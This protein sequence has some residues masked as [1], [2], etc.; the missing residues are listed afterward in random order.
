ME[1][2]NKQLTALGI[3]PEELS[4]QAASLDLSLDEIAKKCASLG[5]PAI[6]LVYAFT[7]FG[8]GGFMVTLATALAAPIGVIGDSLTGYTIE[9]LLTKFY[10][11][12]RQ[13]EPL[14]DLLKEIDSLLL[15]E[16][17]KIKLKNQLSAAKIIEPKVTESPRII[18]IV[19]E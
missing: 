6:F 15:T 12:R 10:L 18:T 14:E 13:Q 16:E 2:V 5:L 3:S 17:L 19:E 9:I 7:T 8:A 4:K 1:E 11:D